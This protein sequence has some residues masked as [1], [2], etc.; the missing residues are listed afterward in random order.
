MSIFVFSVLLPQIANQVGWFTAEMGRQPWVVY[1]L[2]RTSDALSKSVSANQVLSSLIM[3]FII[4]SIL[5]LLFLYLLNK[6]IK[7]GPYDEK[8]E[9]DRPLQN[10]ISNLITG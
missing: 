5:F 3:F 7:H 1:G 4:Y 9:D 10:E 2:L 6:K 8:Q